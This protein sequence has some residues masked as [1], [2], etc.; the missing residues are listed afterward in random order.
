M[1][2]L[3]ESGD[4][5]DLPNMGT[6]KSSRV[7]VT[8]DRGSSAIENI[9]VEEDAYDENS[10]KFDVTRRLL[11][12]DGDEA[13]TLVLGHTALI[14]MRG[15]DLVFSHPYVNLLSYG[16]EKRHFS[17]ELYHDKAVVEYNYELDLETDF[18]HAFD[19]A[20]ND[21]FEASNKAEKRRPTSGHYAT[22][23][24]VESTEKKRGPQEAIQGRRLTGRLV[25]TDKA[26]LR[27]VCF[28]HSDALAV[29]DMSRGFLRVFD[30]GCISGWA[31]PKDRLGTA[32][33]RVTFAYMH[34]GTDQSH[35]FGLELHE[36]TLCFKQP[37]RA[38]AIL[39]RAQKDA[40]PGAMPPLPAAYP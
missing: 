36:V 26:R 5:T 33:K 1:Q 20:V 22:T 21:A 40:R 37:T 30:W 39:Q 6:P 35:H 24:H 38:L 29:L 17:Y 11:S 4:N 13:G 15:T 8:P 9:I 34:A 28:L 2:R 32:R 31:A 10:R 14:F 23:G 25:G 12:T 3:I 18:L 19:R 16:M 7:I 27:V